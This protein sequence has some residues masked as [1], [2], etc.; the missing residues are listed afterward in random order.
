MKSLR[1]R[2]HLA[3]LGILLIL[4]PLIAPSISHAVLRAQDQS[5]PVGWSLGWCSPVTSA[6][7]GPSIAT[8]ADG[9]RHGDLAL[10]PGDAGLDAPVAPAHLASACDYCGWPMG[11]SAMLSLPAGLATDSPLRHGLQARAD[12]PSPARPQDGA[13]GVR[14]PPLT[15]LVP[16]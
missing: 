16:A 1:I 3:W 9:A 5:T 4:M 13:H 10:L 15:S 2:A 6:A 11:S 12:I 7:T 14:A 8:L